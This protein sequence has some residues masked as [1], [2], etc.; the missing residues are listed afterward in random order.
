MI[1]YTYWNVYY[2]N[3]QDDHNISEIGTHEL[4][5]EHCLS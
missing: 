5:T 2:S 1:D 4:H 3:V